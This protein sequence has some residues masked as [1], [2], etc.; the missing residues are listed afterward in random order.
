MATAG[1]VIQAG[2]GVQPAP[3]RLAQWWAA[4]RAGKTG[5]LFLAPFAIVF[6]LFTVLPVLTALGLSFTYYNMLQPPHWIGL[7]NYRNLF[8]EDNTFLI[9]VKNTFFFAVIAGP[10]TFAA[11]FLLAWLINM[12]RARKALTLIYYAPSLTSAVAMSL[13]FSYFLS[14]DRYGLLNDLLM[15]LGVINEPYQFLKNVKSIMPSII[16]VQLWM[17]LG[18]GFLVNLAGLNAVDRNLYEAAAMDGIRTKLQEMW[19]ITLPMMKPQL[20]F[21]AVNAIVTSFNVFW[22]SAALVG[23]PSPQYAGHTIVGVLYDHAFIRFELGYASAVAVVL[24][25][26]TLGLNRIVFRLLST[27]GDY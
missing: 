14:G 6:F 22:I 7:V 19:Y 17:G 3:G 25:L 24:F 26:F 1:Q 5:Y 10:A 2:A 13:I 18:N 21:N 23:F 4:V 12:Q 16:L 27:K 8:L 20:L 9:G 15:R 11:S